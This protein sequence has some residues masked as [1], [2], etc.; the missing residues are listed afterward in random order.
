[1]PLVVVLRRRLRWL[2]AVRFRR[3]QDDLA[4]DGQRLQQDV[5]AVPILVHERGADVEPV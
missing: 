4:V 2:V 5:V 1:M 3:S